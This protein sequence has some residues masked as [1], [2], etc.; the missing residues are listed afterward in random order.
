[1]QFNAT[2]VGM[3]RVP[4]VPE[5]P[6]IASGTRTENLGSGNRNVALWEIMKDD[7]TYKMLFIK[8]I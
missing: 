3:C 1:M 4:R 8:Q 7:L 2:K 6:T 5:Y